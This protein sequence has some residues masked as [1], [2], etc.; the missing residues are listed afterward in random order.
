MRNRAGRGRVLLKLRLRWEGGHPRV[1]CQGMIS[2][3]KE[4]GQQGG[5]EGRRLFPWGG[6]ERGVSAAGQESR[7]DWGEE[8]EGWGRGEWAGAWSLADFTST[9]VG[10]GAT[11]GEH[12][13]PCLP[14]GWG[15]ALGSQKFRVGRAEGR[16]K[17]FKEEQSSRKAVGWIALKVLLKQGP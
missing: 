14:R 7:W 13:L 17:P 4:Q 5:A 6:R 8:Q 3:R 16:D 12:G 9:H 11:R 1:T 10:L 2:G 15:C